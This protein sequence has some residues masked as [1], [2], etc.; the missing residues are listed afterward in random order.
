MD[1][2]SGSQKSWMAMPMSLKQLPGLTAS[3][4]FHMASKVASERRFPAIVG[5]PIRYM[6]ELSPKNSPS[7]MVMSMLTMSPSLSFFLSL[8]MPWQIT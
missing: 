7:V 4:P 3:M 8:G 1:S 6:R 5:L 2:P